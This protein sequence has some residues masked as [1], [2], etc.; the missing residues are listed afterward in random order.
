MIRIRLPNHLV[1]LGVEYGTQN[2]TNFH[3]QIESAYRY[4]EELIGKPVIRADGGSLIE[5]E[6]EQELML[7]KLKFPDCYIE[8][9]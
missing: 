9:Y 7:F 3:E 5:F 4:I 6:D 1:E 8:R 2:S